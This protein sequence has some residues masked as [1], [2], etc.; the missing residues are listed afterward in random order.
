M[1]RAGVHTHLLH[2]RAE[3]TAPYTVHLAELPHLGHT[4]VRV[5]GQTS[6][7]ETSLLLLPRRPHL[8]TDGL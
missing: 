8:P 2:R 3:Q 7:L 1:V 5:A 6:A 4:H